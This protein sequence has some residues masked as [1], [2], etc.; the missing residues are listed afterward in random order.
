M[1]KEPP[2]TG[3]GFSDDPLTP[4][5]LA[6]HREMHRFVSETHSTVKPLHEIKQ[7]GRN[8]AYV[9]GFVGILGG[10]AAW[11]AKQGFFS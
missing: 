6:S 4:D 2:F 9:I 7:G 5:D 10:A 11:A 8:I 1:S 3:A